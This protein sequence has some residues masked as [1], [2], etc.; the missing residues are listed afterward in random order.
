MPKLIINI[1]I[2]YFQRQK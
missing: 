2:N 1:K